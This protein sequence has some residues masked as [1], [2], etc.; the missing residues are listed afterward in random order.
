M[1]R[2]GKKARVNLLLGSCLLLQSLQ[3]SS[4]GLGN[5]VHVDKPATKSLVHPQ[6]LKLQGLVG[7]HGLHCRH[8]VA[9][10]NA[11]SRYC[12][13]AQGCCGHTCNAG[14]PRD[15]RWHSPN[16]PGCTEC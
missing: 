8:W 11:A 10:K 13:T 3:L 2:G 14:D 15:A 5:R 4:L 12:G 7:T 16:T 1:R 9:T 6:L